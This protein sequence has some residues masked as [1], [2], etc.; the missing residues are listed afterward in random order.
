MVPM[1]QPISDWS[2]DD[3]VSN[4]KTAKE[5]W[6]T[7]QQTHEG[8]TYV[9]RARINTLMHEYELLNMKKEEF[10]N[11]M[12]TRFTHIVNH[13]NALGK[14]IDNEQQISKVMRCLTRE[15]QPKITAIAESKDLGSIK[16]KKFMKKK[17]SKSRKPSNS[18]THDSKITCFECGKTGHIKSECFQLQNINKTAKAKG[19]QPPPK[20][21]KAY[22]AW[23][24]ND[25][26]S[27]A[28]S[29]EKNHNKCGI[30]YRQNRN[31]KKNQKFVRSKHMHDIFTK[32]NQ[33]SSSAVSCHFCCKKGHIVFNCKLKK[34]A[35]K[36]W[37]QIWKVKTPMFETNPPGPNLNWVCF[38]SQSCIIEHKEN[39]DI[40]MVGDRV[41]NIYMLDFNALPASTIC[42][43]LSN[44][45]ENWLWHKRVAHIHIDH[46]NKL[47]SKQLVL[48]LPNR[49]F[50]KDKLCDFC[51]KSNTPP[52]V[53]DSLDEIVES[54]PIEPNETV[55]PNNIDC[56]EPIREDDL[57]KEWK[58]NKNHPIDNIIGEISRGV[59]TRA[60]IG[61]SIESEF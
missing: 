15:W 54:E 50:T 38:T 6:D 2:E 8:T 32:P 28:S 37:K 61:K 5:M 57:P 53:G 22:I 33:N 13:L 29:E 42:C 36:G 20:T 24:D 1:C 11:D 16:F 25:E 14:V 59:A 10:V 43:L 9:K 49:K 27:S 12:Q 21:R 52:I 18:K 3:K 56:I 31:A 19:N 55:P 7:L 41:N 26:E 4:C 47:V 51:E 44:S 17:D 45:D 39:K 34:L 23:N 60:S 48:G 40:K 58:F 30:G 46:L 35:N